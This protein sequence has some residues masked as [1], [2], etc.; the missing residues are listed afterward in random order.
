MGLRLKNTYSKRVETFVARD[1]ARPVTIYTCGPTVYS[2][3]HIGNFRS[4][5]MADVLRR[6]LER[7][8]HRVRHVMNIT[9][10]GHLTEDHVADPTGEDKLAK[11]GRALGWDPYRVARHFESSF[12]E[13]A[14][15][16]RIQTRR[17]A[18]PRAELMLGRQPYD[19]EADRLRYGVLAELAF[20]YDTQRVAASDRREALR[21][22][23]GDAIDVVL[24]EPEY[25]RRVAQFLSRD[26]FR[27]EFQ[28]APG[29]PRI[30]QAARW[31]PLAVESGATAAAWT[32]H[33]HRQ[34]RWGAR[35]PKGPR[36]R[37]GSL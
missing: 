14:R 36:R 31:E 26:G 21:Q 28:Q 33:R 7:R 17:V 25:E 15:A 11:A 16:L 35:L 3:S 20:R 32:T 10:V 13:D 12:V 30:G 1:A 9:D 27:P 24:R 8:G 5:L 37:G 4:F 23:D 29:D 6:V 34:A 18:T 2:H 19:H 22:R